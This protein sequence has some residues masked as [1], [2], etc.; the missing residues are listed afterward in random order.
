MVVFPS[1]P[2]VPEHLPDILT[3]A[4]IMQVLQAVR[5]L[6]HRVVLMLAY[7]AGL[8]ISEVC[9]LQVGDIDS[10]RMVVDTDQR[11]AMRAIAACRTAALGAHV[12]VCDSCGH[13]RPAYNSCRNRHCPKCQSLRLAVGHRSAGEGIRCTVR[14]RED[15]A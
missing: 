11:A 1:W 7:G 2:Q 15:P 6:K 13:E 10:R 9:S 5:S 3:P 8:R 4:E 12:D 14:R